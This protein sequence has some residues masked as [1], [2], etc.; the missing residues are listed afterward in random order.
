MPLSR[1]GLRL[2]SM[3]HLLLLLTQSSVRVPDPAVL[4]GG[5]TTLFWHRMRPGYVPPRIGLQR[6]PVLVSSGR[7]G[8][9][10]RRS[11]IIVRGT[12]IPSLRTGIVKKVCHRRPPT[13]HA[14]THLEALSLSST[15]LQICLMLPLTNGLY[16]I[17]PSRLWF[18]AFNQTYTPQSFFPQGFS[19]RDEI[20]DREF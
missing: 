11:R 17:A 1:S 14:P 6:T 5:T 15:A 4:C 13:S 2:P 3:P 19:E 18:G 7:C 10:A 16:L 8:T 12:L 20:L 9:A